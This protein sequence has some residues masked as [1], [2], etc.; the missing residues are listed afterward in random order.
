MAENVRPHKHK[1]TK[2]IGVGLVP[3][4]NRPGQFDR[5]TVWEC[6][7]PGCHETKRK[8]KRVKINGG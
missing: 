2:R 7:E 4:K 6:Y 5:V 8:T 3:V 1:F